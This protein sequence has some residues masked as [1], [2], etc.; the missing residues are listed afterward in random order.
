M[1]ALSQQ[2]A[3]QI[4]WVDGAHYKIICLGSQ[5]HVPNLRVM[6]NKS[7]RSKVQ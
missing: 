1:F 4:T 2:I 5:E 6:L 3:L 7:P